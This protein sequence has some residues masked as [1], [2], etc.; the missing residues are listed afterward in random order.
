MRDLAGSSRRQVVILT[1]GVFVLQLLFIV[2]YVG[3][4]GRPSPKQLPV[5]IVGSVDATR[6]I[7]AAV[8]EKTDA[9]A[10]RRFGTESA[11]RTAIDHREIYGAIVLG[12]K[13]PTTDLVIVSQAPSP[14]PEQA[15]RKGVA[16]IDQLTHRSAVYEVVHRLPE[17][18]AEGLSLFYLIVGWVVGGYLIGTVLGLARGTAPG[19]RQ[20]SARIGVYAGYAVVSGLAGAGLLYGLLDL[21]PGTWLTLAAVGALTSFAASSATGAFQSLIGDIGTAVAILL[22]VVLGNPGSAGPFTHEFLSGIWHAVGPWLPPGAGVE[23][24]R[25]V[26]Y[27]DGWGASPHLWV[28]VAWSVAG[29][30]VAAVLSMRRDPHAETPVPG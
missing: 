16:S 1:V 23:A 14:F 5:G 7:S 10:F 21:S 25:S 29:V 12:A 15:I 13:G 2:S 18:D 11:A 22:F 24:A 28:L 8:G 20:F 17:G 6:A 19:L 3:G 26:T 27:F 4:L 9:F 30:G